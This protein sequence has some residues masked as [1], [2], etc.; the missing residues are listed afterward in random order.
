MMQT[1][2]GLER[3]I[4]EY[5]SREESVNKLAAVSREKIQEALT[6]KEQAQAKVEQCEQEVARLQNERKQL[7]VTRQVKISHV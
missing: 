2:A 1:M 7:L 3:Q 6:I 5:A 4:Q